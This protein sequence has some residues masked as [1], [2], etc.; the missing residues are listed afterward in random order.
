MTELIKRGFQ[1]KAGNDTYLLC[2]QE[3]GIYL[4]AFQPGQ[5]QRWTIIDNGMNQEGVETHDYMSEPEVL[6]LVDSQLSYGQ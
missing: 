1:Y 3:K 6:D 5:G 4:V 2:N